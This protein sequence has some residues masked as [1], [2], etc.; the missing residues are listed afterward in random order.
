MSKEE[1]LLIDGIPIEELA[2]HWTAGIQTGPVLDDPEGEDAD[3]AIK[4]RKED[5]DHD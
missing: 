5:E 1:P 4:N 2:N 3:W